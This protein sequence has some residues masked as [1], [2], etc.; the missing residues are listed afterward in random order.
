[1]I[2]CYEKFTA[3]MHKFGIP[4]LF[5]LFADE[6]SP[7][8][9]PLREWIPA[10]NT[11]IVATSQI[12][13]HAFRPSLVK[14]SPTKKFSDIVCCPSEPFVVFIIVAEEKFA[15]VRRMHEWI[16]GYKRHLCSTSDK[17]LFKLY[18]N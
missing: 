4:F 5:L 12:S 14:V 2:I 18:Q 1:M 7:A 3:R 16:S 17:G 11:A 9:S 10:L 8:T 15:G 13:T 6:S